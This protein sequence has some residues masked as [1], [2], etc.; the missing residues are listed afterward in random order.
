[1]TLRTFVQATKAMS[2]FTL[3][4]PGEGVKSCGI[5]AHLRCLS[6][7]GEVANVTRLPPSLLARQAADRRRQATSNITSTDIAYVDFMETQS[8]K[9]AFDPIDFYTPHLP[10]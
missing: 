4:V 1:M 6:R 7:F 9:L 3:A 2:A 8:C 5:N 10:W